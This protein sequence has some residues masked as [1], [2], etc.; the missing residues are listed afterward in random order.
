MAVSVLSGYKKAASYLVKN[1]LGVESF[2]DR[3][4]LLA[5]VVQHLREYRPGADF[6]TAVQKLLKQEK[7]SARTHAV[8]RVALVEAL[9]D[10]STTGDVKYLVSLLRKD[11]SWKVRRAILARLAGRKRQTVLDTALKALEDPHPVIKRL[12]LAEAVAA[13]A[14]KDKRPVYLAKLS[15]NPTPA[16][17]DEILTAEGLSPDLSLRTLEELQGVLAA[18]GAKIR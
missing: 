7:I 6:Y 3:P 11:S 18:R 15:Q 9:F 13:T 5:T 14:K 17:C 4:E 8:L 10:R 2:L 1:V 12:A 16:V